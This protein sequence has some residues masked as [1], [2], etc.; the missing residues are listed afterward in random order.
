MRPKGGRVESAMAIAASGRLRR[1]VS[2]GSKS[3]EAT[4][5]HTNIST[6]GEASKDDEEG[7]SPPR[8]VL[9]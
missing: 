2:R 5:A 3:E 6:L 9:G 4:L 7:T 1:E 8:K